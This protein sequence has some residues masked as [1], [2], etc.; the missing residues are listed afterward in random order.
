MQTSSQSSDGE[1]DLIN[2]R[3]EPNSTS[4]KETPRDNWLLQEKVSTVLRVKPTKEQYSNVTDINTCIRIR[5]S[6]G[7]LSSQ[8]VRGMK[9]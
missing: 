7:S 3:H 9:P 2:H 5:T 6:M 8:S 4:P 1:S